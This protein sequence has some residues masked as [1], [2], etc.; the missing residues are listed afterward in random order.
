MKNRIEEIQNRI[1]TAALRSSRRPEEITLVAV[2][3]T[4]PVE[5]IIEAINSGI[6]VIGEN[7]IQEAREKYEQLKDSDL[8]WHFIGHLQSN[9]AKYAVKIF[10][11]IQTVD[12]LKLAREIDKQAKKINKIQDILV[13]VNIGEEASKSG[14]SSEKTL[15][16]IKE[17][18]LLENIAI[19]G[20]MTIP[21]YY[22]EPDKVGP[23]FKAL[24]D[25]RDN[26]IR[27]NIPG[28]DLNGLSMGMSG[29]FEVAIENGAT[30]VRVGTAIFGE[31]N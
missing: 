3:K 29:D 13:Q 1:K 5:D 12:S 31:R 16:L 2:S 24:R 11:L 23:F 4:K 17:I 6:N 8:S 22:D 20:L 7:Y 18:S 26:I 28:I 10:D 27:E 14:T 25:L 30:L 21:P 15:N 19:K 9:K